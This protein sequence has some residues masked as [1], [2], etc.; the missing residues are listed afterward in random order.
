MIHSKTTNKLLGITCGHVLGMGQPDGELPF[1]FSKTKDPCIVVYKSDA[2]HSNSDIVTRTKRK[3]DIISFLDLSTAN[4]T[5]SLEFLLVV[6]IGFMDDYAGILGFRKV[7][8]EL[9]W[10]ITFVRETMLDLL[11]QE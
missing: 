4:S 8:R 9:L 1:N 5:C 7:E 3:S 2:D 6:R 11:Q 10:R